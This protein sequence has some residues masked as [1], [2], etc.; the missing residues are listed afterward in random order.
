MGEWMD[1]GRY[2]DGWVDGLVCVGVCKWVSD[3]WIDESVLR[4]VQKWEI[5]S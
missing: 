4:L 1:G 3:G 2:M 5:R